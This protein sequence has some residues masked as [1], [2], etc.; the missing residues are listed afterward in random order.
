LAGVG[1]TTRGVR[2]SA[3]NIVSRFGIAGEM[4]DGHPQYFLPGYHPSLPNAALT[5]DAFAARNR[6]RL[7]FPACVLT[8]PLSTTAL[9]LS[10][11][12]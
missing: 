1:S 5:G 11:S 10:V 8:F 2:F 4:P 9:L 3:S 7:R 6:N 12:T